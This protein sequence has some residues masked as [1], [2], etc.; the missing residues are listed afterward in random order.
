MKNWRSYFI[1]ICFFLLAAAVLSRLAFLQTKKYG[2]YKALAEGQQKIIESE[3]GARGEIFFRNGEP[4]AINKTGKYVYICPREI[5]EKQET[6]KMLAGA[7]DLD[8]GWVE[9][10]VIKDNLF[11]V[12]KRRLTDEEIAVLTEKD[13]VGAYIKDDIYRYYPHQELAAHVSG[14]LNVDGQGQYGVE[15]FYDELLRGE[16]VLTEKQ[17]SPFG[18]FS[19]KENESFGE[20]IVLT[21]DPSIQA[22]AEELL[23][24]YQ[25]SLAF[26]SG[27]ILVLQP[28]SGEIIALAQWPGFNPNFYSEVKEVDD[29]QNAFLQ[30]IF[31]P[32]S[33]FKPI[34]MSAAINENKITPQ[35][36]YVD[37][38][39]VEIGSDVINNYDKRVYGAQT[40][41]GVLEK[42]INTGAVFAERALGDRLFVQY[43]DDF[44]FFEKTNIDLQGEVFSTNLEFKKGYEINFATASFGQGIEITPIQIASAFAAIANGGKSITPHVLKIPN[45]ALDLS[46]QKQII[47]EETSS[48]IVNMLLSV[49]ENGFGKAAKIDGYYVAGKT[50]TA[51]VSWPALGIQKSG[52]SDKTAQTFIGFIPAFNPE[53]LVM[54]KLDN[55]QTKTA[56]YSAV[57]IF[58]ELGKYIVDY[59]QIAPDYEN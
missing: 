49:I 52:Y 23:A 11:E 59:L 53:F 2:Y 54:V 12:I 48:Q 27:Q 32:G 18:F 20:D 21:I 43:I 17:K 56:E 15:G 4:L 30:K 35:T 47:S 5:K 33:V 45:D 42:S 38:G 40:M 51:Q 28:N 44:G 3:I 25:Q 46:G 50:G 55:P 19:S 29:F 6:T 36:S 24:K 8:E 39:I 9:E 13:L 7:L 41:T 57:P 37:T 10:R 22:L 58:K 26:E 34:V 16:E 31:E 1:L 14:F